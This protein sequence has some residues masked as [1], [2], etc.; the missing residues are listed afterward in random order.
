MKHYL[1]YILL[2]VAVVTVTI[3]QSFAQST[4]TVEID[5]TGNLVFPFEDEGEFQ[6]PDEIED[7]PLYL[8][9]PKNIVQKYEYDP[10]T[11]QYIIYEKIGDMYYRM[12]K[13]MGLKEF[14]KYDFD[15]SI[16][17]YWRTRK[18]TEDIEVQQSR[19][20][21][22]LRIESEA[23]NNIF[24][25]EVID[26]RPQG[27]VEV[28]FG[29]ESNYIENPILPER[30]QR[31]TTFDFDNQINISVAG[32]IGDKVDLDFN[33]NTE[34]SFDF[35]NK[36]NLEYN[37][38]EDEILRKIEAGNVSLPL[39]G[40]LI[41]G[42][43]NL[44]G[45]KTEMQFGRLNLT[46]VISQH[47]G[48]SQVIETEGGAQKTTFNIKA[49]EYD[50]NR[51]FFVSKYFYDHYNEAL[52]NLPLIRTQIKINRVEVWVTNKNQNFTSARNIVGFV[53][54]GEITENIHNKVTS[55]AGSGERYPSNSAN[56]MYRTL[57]NNYSAIRTSSEVKATIGGISGFENGIDWDKIDQARRLSESEYTLNN[58]LGYISLN[59]PLNSDE[60]LAIA[61]EYTLGGNLYQVGE[62]SEDVSDPEES[63]ILKLI[64]G[65]TLSPEFPTW[66][67]MMKNIYNLG[68]YDLSSDD[69]DF[70]VVYKNEET[71]TYANNIPDGELQDTSLLRLMRLDNLNSQLDGVPNG[72]GSFDFI[73]GITVI[74]QSG[75][76]IF[77][78]LEPFGN[79]ITRNLSDPKL[80][81]KYAY[82]TLY[83]ESKTSAEN[84]T[85]HDRFALMGSYKGTSGAEIALNAFNLAPGSVQVSAGGRELEEDIDYVV[86]YAMGRVKI[87]NEGLIE[88][89]TPI[90]VSTESQELISTQRKTMIGTYASYMASE[91]LNIGG[92]MLWMNE[93]PITNKV[94]MGEEP[95][96]NLML[97]L[98]FQYRDRSQLLTD[99]V[100]L[101]PFYDSDV[102]SSIS[103]EG[104]VA[105][106]I[107]GSSNTTGNQVYID[108]FEGVETA[109]SFINTTGWSLASTPQKQAGI[110]PES[111]FDND[112]LAYGRN[113][114]KL[115]W[116][117]I[118]RN[119][120]NVRSS[121]DMPV[122]LKNDLEALSNHY[123]REV[124][125]YEIYPGKELPVG[126][127]K[128][129]YVMNL[130]FYPKE[131]G[132][133]NFDAEP[134]GISAGIDDNGFL[135]NPSSRWGGIMREIHTPNFEA[136][137]VRYI[138]FWMLDPFIYNEDGSNKGGDLYFNLGSVS[139]DILKDSKKAFE[140][141][142]PIGDLVANVD[143]SV[144][145]RVSN[146]T[147]LGS[148]FETVENSREFQDIGLDGL[149]NN[150]EAT[151]FNDYLVKLQSILN[152]TAYNKVAADPANDDFDYYRSTEFDEEERSVLDR[153]KNYNNP[154]GNSKTIEMSD[155]AYQ[156]TGKLGPDIED[157]NEDN[158]LSELES[159][160]QYRVSIRPEDMNVGQNFIVDKVTRSV[161]LVNEVVDTV[162]WYQF[163]IPV[164]DPSAYEAINRSEDDFTS[165]R[166]MRMFLRD[167]SDS[168][169]LRF[170]SLNLVR[171]DWRKETDDMTEVG[172]TESSDGSI[173]LTSI[174]IEENNSRKPI[175]YILPPEIERETDPSSPTLI[176]MNEQSMLLKVTNLEKGDIKAVYKNLGIDMRQYKRL[177]MEVHAEEI[178]G[179]PLSDNELSLIIRLGSDIDNYYEY[180]IPLKL[181][182]ERA[183]AYDSDIEADRYIVW[184]NENRL[185]IDLEKFSNLKLERDAI[186]RQANSTL[187][188][189][190]IHQAID[191]DDKF[192]KNRI[193]VKGNPSLGDVQVLY[194]G[195][196][197]PLRKNLEAK[198]V[199]LW[200]NELRM[201]DFEEKGG[202]A[203][204]GRMSVR[205]A[206]L[207]SVSLSGQTQS[208][209]WGS[210]NQVASQR[211]LDN[212]YQFD[213]AAT[214]QIGKLLPE[215][216]GL[217]MPLFYS[218]SKSVA[219]PEYNPFS[220]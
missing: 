14:V 133:Y 211:S 22:Q 33:Y 58:Q 127:P 117:Y 121:S 200:I 139:E 197:N 38:K 83:N 148:G 167:F 190:D 186:I 215:K 194:I 27:Y 152:Q 73:E 52:A 16:K 21:P 26:I 120:F 177:R 39:N 185:D 113:R 65:T 144:W 143:T 89:G 192:S 63:L 136:A 94:E 214:T 171:A 66:E 175:N 86:D 169:I 220:S 198:S 210:I 53:D 6:Y 178:E 206:D 199:E 72:D 93:R 195:V 59:A 50:Q 88:A 44:F 116:F 28:L 125:T 102:E 47:K 70:Q 182:P 153:Y 9:R 79:N 183:T 62:F 60:V 131:K 209:G 123:T 10:E 163:K 165:I 128:Y 156:I 204:N 172:G 41:Q 170:A 101:L 67:L 119:V 55:F 61:F 56:G 150:D 137:N 82:N 1:N 109:Y 71:N 174:N 115:A 35:E 168:V 105:K 99:V 138:E 193:K 205:L 64:K 81:E 32:K 135:L 184:P 208:V 76:I 155:E 17:D 18:E 134:T 126:S 180:E 7:K 90:Q 96:T 11:Q 111:N 92:T 68:A 4:N 110:F 2:C 149:N 140:N 142:L 51:H 13:T 157:I 217:N 42:G 15:R 146:K 84:D 201:S 147:Q 80:Q 187:S 114:A 159:Y 219:K 151:F 173:E 36:M 85:E 212:K 29:L 24:G 132:P 160:Y 107:T 158:T 141:G 43:T 203:S 46:T 98:D 12:P 75:R 161:E 124:K 118:D 145:G 23:F 97:G 191:S 154:D 31:V 8:S 34:A 77:P 54:L 122:H 25:S 95:V 78:L 188:R 213:I 103:I 20:I 74:Q 3:S 216:L 69:F 176:Q 108:D 104:E 49:S 196:S 57:V 45:I 129:Q 112:T 130:A 100:N 162:H 87:I 202:W 189:T 218:I 37:G 106:L 19:L 5:T 40:T 179:Y 48:E 207:G 164:Q 30:Q 181:T 91:K 166:F